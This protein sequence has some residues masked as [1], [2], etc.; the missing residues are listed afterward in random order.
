VSWGIRSRFAH[1]DTPENSLT[2]APN[3][4][5]KQSDAAELLARG[6]NALRQHRHIEARACYR[7]LLENGLA[8]TAAMHYRLALCDEVFGKVEDATSSYR[9]AISVS[10][11]RAL[12]YASHLGMA[13]CLLRQNRFGEARQL[14]I[15]FLLNETRHKD[16]QEDLV[17]EAYY[18]V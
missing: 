8:N 18:L 9:A 14:L 4:R 10:S 15:P 17:T 16:V 1:V 2:E 11:A 12:T 7:D 5:V 13:R 3:Q 6:D